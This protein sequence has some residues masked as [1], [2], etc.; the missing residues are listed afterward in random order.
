MITKLTPSSE[1]E[2][3]FAEQLINKS[4]GK[5]NKISPNSVLSGVAA[6]VAKIG[7]KA[8]KEIALI[9]SATFPDSATGLMLDVVAQKLGISPRFGSSESSTFVRIV[10]EEGTVYTPGIHQFTTDQ[11]VT[12]DLEEEVEVGQAGFT[13]TKVRSVTK[14]KRAN[15]NP[16]SINTMTVEPTG[17]IY[18]INE[19][20]A[21]GGR[22]EEQDDVFRLRIKEGANILAKGTIAS[23]EQAMNKINPNVLRVFYQGL[24]SLG[25]PIIAIAT[26]NGINLNQSELDLLLEKGEEFFSIVDLRP[27]GT[28]SY[29]LEL[30]NIEYQ[31]IDISFRAALLQNANPDLVRIEIQTRISKLLD[32]RFW[33]PGG[34]VEWDDLLLAVKQTPGVRYVPDQQFFPRVDIPIDPAKLP[35]LRGFLMLNLDGSILSDDQGNLD[36]VF[37]PFNADFSFQQTVL[38]SIS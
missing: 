31:P 16:F 27:F 5:V 19:Y 22:D 29:G 10:A 15:V 8:L 26:Q 23:L 13:Y 24:N 37:Y 34:K 21:T 3:I 14:G 9:E 6:G 28:Q 25:K 4:G 36:P 1:L 17:H 2:Q 18:V 20:K 7:Q 11:G 12:F 32:F 35:R 30:R 33:T 38:R